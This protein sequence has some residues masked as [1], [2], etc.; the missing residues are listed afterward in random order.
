MNSKALG[1][2]LLSAVAVMGLLVTGVAGV[3]LPTQANPAAVAA[4][5]QHPG[6]TVTGHPNAT[7][8]GVPPGPP[9]WLNASAPFGPP[10]WVNT[11]GG[12]PAWLML[13]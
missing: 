11:S 10:V 3:S 1:I 4:T 5:Q 13:P 9:A 7:V 12:L 8:N 6:A 2:G